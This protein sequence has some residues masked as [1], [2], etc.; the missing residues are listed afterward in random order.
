MHHRRHVQ[1]DHLFVERI[2]VLIG[3]RR[4]GPVAA[5][6]VGIQV[7]ADEA[8]LVHAALQLLDDILEA[9]RPATAAA[10]THPRNC[11][12]RA[13]KR[14]ESD[15]CS[16]APIGAGRRGADVMRH[17]GRA[18][19]KYRHVGTALAL[20]LELRAFEALPNLIVTDVDAAVVRRCVGSFSAAI[21][22]SRKSCSALGA[23][24]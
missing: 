21:C 4:R 5:R 11:W 1:L 16:A 3:Q 2:P 20:Q 17:R 10:G 8:E 19:R 12:D 24:V 22:A 13:C 18:R 9:A 6:R 14:D 23:V 7:A 15:R